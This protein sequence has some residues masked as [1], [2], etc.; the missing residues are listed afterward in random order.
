MLIGLAVFAIVADALFLFTEIAQAGLALAL[1]SL[2]GATVF[3]MYPMIVAHANDRA[4]PGTFIQV[5]G[6]LLIVYGIGSIIGPAPAGCSM[7]FFGEAVLFS[8]TGAA[9]V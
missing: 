9:H 5:S 3:K 4:E 6:G 1:S 7:T 2:F 8:V